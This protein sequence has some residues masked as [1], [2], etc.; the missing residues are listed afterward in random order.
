[1][2]K[3]TIDFIR[4]RRR[5]ELTAFYLVWLATI[6]YCFKYLCE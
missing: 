1:M 3:A 2:L 5:W 6:I 4:R